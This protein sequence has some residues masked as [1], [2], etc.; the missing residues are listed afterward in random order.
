MEKSNQREEDPW[1]VPSK[2]NVPRS[3][4][5]MRPSR[6]QLAL[7][8]SRALPPSLSACALCSPMHPS[9]TKIDAPCTPTTLLMQ[10]FPP[11]VRPVLSHAPSTMIDAPCTPT[12]LLM[13]AYA[14]AKVQQFADLFMSKVA[15]NLS[16]QELQQVYES[17]CAQMAQSQ[18]STASRELRLVLNHDCMAS[19][20]PDLQCMLCQFNPS[21]TCVRLLKT[22]W[23]KGFGV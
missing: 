10:A 17:C 6:K 23:D 18:H 4:E 7:A 13:Q 21:R 19:G 22:K 16:P 9:L 14:D 5:L 20:C 2:W 3:R 12:T 1:P 15:S 8:R 11:G